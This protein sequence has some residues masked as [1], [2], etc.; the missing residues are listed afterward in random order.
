CGVAELEPRTG[1]NVPEHADAGQVGTEQADAEQDFS[2][3]LEDFAR[4][5]PTH[6]YA[7]PAADEFASQLD[8]LFADT[9]AP[10]SA[11][12]KAQDA[13]PAETFAG[14][15]SLFGEAK[16]S[17]ATDTAVDADFPAT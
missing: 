6:A 10:D 4:Q 11:E 5:V 16:L 12:R 2:A 8:A 14:V 3:A 13:A 7:A 1:A 9:R 17:A 15:E